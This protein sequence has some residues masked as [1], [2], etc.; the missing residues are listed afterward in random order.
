MI[1]ET[2]SPYALGDI[3]VI[4]NLNSTSTVDAL[5][6]NMGRVLKETLDAIPT[7][8][9]TEAEIDAIFA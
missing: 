7:E 1:P 6:A 4:N 5:S 3:N 8:I 9:A 2:A